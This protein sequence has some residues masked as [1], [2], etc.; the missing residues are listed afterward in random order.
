MKPKQADILR[1]ASTLFNREGYQ[2][3]S[4]ERIAE[5]AGISK[6]TFYRYYA[7]KEAL[8]LAIL[9]QKESEFM[10]DLAQI[11]ADKASAREKLFAVFDYYHRW[12]TCE[13]FHGCMFTRALF[14]YGASSPAIREQ[15][16]RFKS[17]LW[18]FFRDILLQVLKPEPAERVASDDGDA[19]RWRHRR[20]AGR[21]RRM[22]GDPARGDRLER[23]QS[24]YLLRRRYA[25]R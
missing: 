4:I 7:D 3:P 1:H 24:A 22:P 8:I 10:Q 2:S 5:H 6:M 9:K 19:H 11:T 15:C 12:F 13:T 17:L 20:P 16:S 14:E 25:V 23:G 18:Q 21:V